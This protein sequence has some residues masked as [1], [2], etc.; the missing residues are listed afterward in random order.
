[1]LQAIQD[2]MCRNWPDIN[3]NI[4]CQE[5]MPAIEGYPFLLNLLF[6]HLIDNAIKFRKENIH[7]VVKVSCRDYDAASVKHPAAIPG[8]RYNRYTFTDQG[9]GFEQTSAEDIFLIFHRLHQ[10][11][12]YKGSGIGLA[13]CRKIMDIHGG[14]IIAESIPGEGADFH[15]YFPVP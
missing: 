6:H 13:I 5:N 11:G 3:I 15:C 14:F 8:T 7:P 2:D 9:I 4:D 10:K 1:M 12:M